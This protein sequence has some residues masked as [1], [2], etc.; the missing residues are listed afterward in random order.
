[1][2]VGREDGGHIGWAESRVASTGVA[3][4]MIFVVLF[5]QV[6]R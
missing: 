4:E 6:K 5:L 2:A 3:Q 1:M